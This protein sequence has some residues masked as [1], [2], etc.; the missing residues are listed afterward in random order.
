MRAKLFLSLILMVGLA[1]GMFL[2][3]PAAKVLAQTT[4]GCSGSRDE[5][6]Q[7]CSDNLSFCYSAVQFDHELCL[8][9]CGKDDPSC[10]TTCNDNQVTAF[11]KCSKAAIEC[12]KGC[13]AT[14]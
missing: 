12:R 6:M 13:G 11:S 5:C 8:Q 14:G 7:C 3:L 9:A 4:G 2:S 10:R 1:V